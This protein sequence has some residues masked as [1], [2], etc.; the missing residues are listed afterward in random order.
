MDQNKVYLAVFRD[1]RAHAKDRP[2]VIST[3]KLG[4]YNKGI[5]KIFYTLNPETRVRHEKGGIAEGGSM[6]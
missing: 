4:A 3:D 6:V 5:S 1:A 2:E